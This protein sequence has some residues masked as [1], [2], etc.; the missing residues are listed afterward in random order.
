MKKISTLL[1]LFAGLLFSLRLAAQETDLSALVDEN[2]KSDEKEYVSA[3]F[4]GFR[5]VNAQNNWY[6]VEVVEQGRVGNFPATA[7]RG[8]LYGKYLDIDGN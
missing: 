3:T 8:W 6:Q 1:L 7:T 2:S 4:K 5:I